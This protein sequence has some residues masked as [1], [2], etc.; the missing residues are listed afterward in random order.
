MPLDRCSTTPLYLQLYQQLR[1]DYQPD[2]SVHRRLWSIRKMAQNVGVSKTTVEQ[3]YDQLLAEGY[4][5]AVAGSG[6]FY[7]DREHWPQATVASVKPVKP[8]PQVPVPYDFRYGVTQL[9]TPSWNAWKRS[10]RLA[11]RQAEQQP[12]AVYPEAQGLLALREALVPFLKTTRGVDCTADQI[13]ITNG[14]KA[15]LSMLLSI[16]PRGVVGIENPGYR[17]LSDLAASYGHKAES[18]PVTTTG[19]DVS[20][21]TKL[22]PNIVYTTPGHQFPLG[23][24]LPTEK[25]LKLLKWAATNHRL[26]IEDDYDSE[27]RYV[28]HPL[29]ALQSLARANQVAYLGTFSRGIDPTLRMGYVVLPPQLVARYHQ[30]YQYRS[31][32]V[33]GLLQQAMANYFADGSYY[34][35]LSRNRA[36]NRQK[37]QLICQKLKA[38]S[39]IRPIATEAGV[40]MVI[41]IPAIAQS[42]LLHRLEAQGVRIYP[43]DSNWAGMPTADYYLVG[44]AGLTLADLKTGLD[45]LIQVCEQVLTQ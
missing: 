37:Y 32:M 14:S 20:A 17:G 29:P 26:I 43:L 31:E 39:L 3:A 45:I 10:V 42:T 38:T 35:H 6:Y 12:T 36:A 1:D 11:L 23:V 9:L 2:Q 25:R 44:F 33:A 13:V 8:E 34:R 27:Y 15:G 40:H 5:Y 18:I 24:V 7:Q 16:L 30:Q 22:D 4:V 21:V 28:A 19:I 41:Q